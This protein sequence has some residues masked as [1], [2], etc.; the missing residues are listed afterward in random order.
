MIQT[1]WRRHHALVTGSPTGDM[2]LTFE[3]MLLDPE[4]VHYPEVLR[5]MRTSIRVHVSLERAWPE[6]VQRRW[7][8]ERF[9]NE[10]E[11]AVL[12]STREPIDSTILRACYC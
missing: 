8:C 4:I 9:G 6:M 1:F 7:F 10:T 12:E 3:R 5:Q 11:R 2:A